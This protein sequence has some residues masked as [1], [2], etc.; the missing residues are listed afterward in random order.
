MAASW[1]PGA[2]RC[3]GAIP[4]SS[5]DRWSL[6]SRRLNR[7]R[8][9]T[10]RPWTLS[11]VAPDHRAHASTETTVPRLRGTLLLGA[12]VA[13][14]WSVGFFLFATG[15]GAAL[16]RRFFRHSSTDGIS[17]TTTASRVRISCG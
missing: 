3:S 17:R 6:T 10:C 5:T 15:S 14:Q 8:S 7:L 4:L 11:Q 1:R 2:R 16:R 9:T 13:D 12:A